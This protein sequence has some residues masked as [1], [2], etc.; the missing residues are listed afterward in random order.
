MVIDVR[1]IGVKVEIS[2][3][4]VNFSNARVCNR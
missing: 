4:E 3:V 2:D 1:K